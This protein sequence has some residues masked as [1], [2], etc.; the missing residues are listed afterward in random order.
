M[1][2]ECKY[3]LLIRLYFTTDWMKNIKLKKKNDLTLFLTKV[4][5]TNLTFYKLKSIS[6]DSKKKKKL[7]Y[8]IQTWKKI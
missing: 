1:Y 7:S 2:T 4:N 5:K 8:K 3:I 6:I